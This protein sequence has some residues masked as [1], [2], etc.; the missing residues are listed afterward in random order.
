M[1]TRY[2]RIVTPSDQAFFQDR[3]AL[4]NG[5][6]S[7][8]GASIGEAL[9]ANGA[10]VAGTYCSNRAPVDAL[11]D[12]YGPDR[13]EAFPCNV[14]DDCYEPAIQQIVEQAYA[15]KGRIDVL[16]NALGIIAINP[17]LYETR[18]QRQRVWRINYEAN[19]VYSQQ[20]VRKMLGQGSGDIVNI[21]SVTGLRGAGHLIA[22]STS[23]SALIVFTHSLA[24][25]LGPKNIK[26]NCVSPGVVAT[27]AIDEHYDTVAKELLIKNIPLSRLCSPVDI[28]NAVLAILMNGYMTA[29]NIVLHGGKL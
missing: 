3:V 7:D 13:V 22:Y 26:V 5:L 2:L 16:V 10:C 9:L 6:S 15:W 17:F 29:N 11:R 19:V 20:V 24:E 25:E 4:V 8:I 18:E 14:M 21:A 23:K 27:K 12:R 1:S 28:S